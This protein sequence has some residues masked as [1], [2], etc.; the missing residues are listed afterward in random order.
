MPLVCL[1][2]SYGKKG[3]NTALD[4]ALSEERPYS[5]ELMIDML[6][7]FD[8]FCLSKM[9]L[10]TF[11]N[12]IQMNTSV[13][14]RFFASATYKP[15]LMHF[16]HSVP[17]PEGQDSFVFPCTTSLISKKLLKKELIDAGLVEEESEDEI[18]EEDEKE[19]EAK[20]KDKWYVLSLEGM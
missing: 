5:F 7:D 1:Y 20:I 17:W 18:K 15:P 10:T 6:E 14:K 3:G 11:P 4:V 19:K 9:M 8:N 12:M 16:Q 2:P 13:I